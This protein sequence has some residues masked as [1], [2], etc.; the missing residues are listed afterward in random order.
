MKTMILLAMMAATAAAS[1]P[2]Q[3]AAPT[4]DRRSPIAAV[5]ESRATTMSC[6]T[7]PIFYG[8]PSVVAL[9]GE[10]GFDAF[11]FPNGTERGVYCSVRLP[12]DFA[13]DAPVSAVITGWGKSTTPTCECGTEHAVFRVESKSSRVD[14]KIPG[15]WWAAVRQDV[16]VGCDAQ[17]SHIFG[18]RRDLVFP[19]DQGRTARPGD[20]LL[21]LVARLGDD[22][23]DTYDHAVVILD[24]VTLVYGVP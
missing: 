4:F 2:I 18:V 19:L 20:L 12:D 14:E 21:L 22:P 11:E 24:A 23:A 7:P 8:A 13:S 15:E 3:P 9:S 5:S 16:L 10:A 17:R 6:V 1:A